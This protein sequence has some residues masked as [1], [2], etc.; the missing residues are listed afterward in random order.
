MVH[1]YSCDAAITQQLAHQAV[2]GSEHLWV[3]HP[4]AD[5]LIDVK[6]SPVI[7]LLARNHPVREPVGLSIQ[8]AVQRIEAVAVP[9][10]PVAGLQRALNKLAH[11]RG[12]FR[13]NGEPIQ[14][15]WGFSLSAA[16]L[17]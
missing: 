10:L 12:M 13:Q 17:L 6:K 3:L 9:G 7:D 8:Q 1:S 2:S 14:K 11:L 5:Q 4:Q 15:R 16:D